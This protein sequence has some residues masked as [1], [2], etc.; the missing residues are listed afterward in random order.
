MEKEQIVKA[1]ECCKLNSGSAC[2]DCPYMYAEL[3][4]DESCSQ[5][6]A[7]NVLA[8]IKEQD[9]QIF[10][11][12]NRLKECENGYSQTLGIERA[13]IKALTEENERLSACTNLVPTL[14]EVKADI[15][16]K[17]ADLLWQ[18]ENEKLN[19]SVG[20]KYYDKQQFID[21][22]ANEILNVNAEEIDS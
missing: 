11:L 10:K 15:V 8:L 6:M 17:I 13:K 14:N 19:I 5:R 9:E 12:E 18:G 16:R 2:S 22:I 7:L 3:A 20:G 21:Q 1:L 4:D